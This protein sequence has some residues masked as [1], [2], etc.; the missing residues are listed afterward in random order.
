MN[1]KQS[2][3]GAVSIIFLAG[4]IPVTAWHK[5][6]VSQGRVNHEFTNCQVYAAKEVPTSI[7][8]KVTGGFFVGY[9]WVPTTSDVDTNNTLRDKVVAQCMS[10]KGFQKVELPL[11]PSN[12]KAPPMDKPAIITNKSC[13]KALPGGYYAIAQKKK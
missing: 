13:F 1:Y 7:E 5:G 6:N 10:Q 4:C 2:V 8:N 3:A 9:L 12:V 11:C